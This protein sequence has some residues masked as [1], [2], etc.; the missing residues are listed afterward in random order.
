[1][2]QGMFV[3]ESKFRESPGDFI[4]HILK[5]NREALGNLITKPAVEA[6]LLVRLEKK[7]LMYGQDVSSDGTAK[8][9]PDNMKIDVDKV[10]S[11]YRD[12]IIPLTKEVEVRLCFTFF[13]TLGMVA[14]TGRTLI[15]VDYLLQR[16]DGVSKEE[17]EKLSKQ[18]KN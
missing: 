4:P 18:K 5:P 11:L 15:Q 9:D 13:F 6:A 7:A 1:M 3:S 10:V 2:I 17:I 14:L 12:H 8:V 16:L